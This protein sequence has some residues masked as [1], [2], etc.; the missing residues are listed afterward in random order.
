MERNN[1]R[2]KSKT[3]LQ[4]LI[5]KYAARVDREYFAISLFFQPSPN[6]LH[7]H[8]KVTKGSNYIHKQNIS[9]SKSIMKS[10]ITMT[11]WKFD[12][13]MIMFPL[14]LLIICS[15]P[16]VNGFE[17]FLINNLGGNTNLAVHC[18]SPQVK[19]L[20][21]RV[22][23][24]GDDFHWE[25]GIN[26]GTTAEYECD[27]GYGNKQKRFLVFAERRDALRCG[28]QKCYWRVDRDGLYLYIKEVDDY[29]KQFSW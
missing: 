9:N 12:E 6:A 16:T 24:P 23:L 21:S 20:G 17:V 29:Q 22:I 2:R 14:V 13:Q 19:D 8:V 10:T 3:V 7:I 27:M 18:F 1:K 26:I 28:N 5:K 25:F 11:P 4:R 15:H